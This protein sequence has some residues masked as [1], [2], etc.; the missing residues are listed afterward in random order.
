MKKNVKFIGSTLLVCIVMV[1]CESNELDQVSEF[2]ELKKANLGMIKSYD[3]AM[4][5]KWNEA[6]SLA[7]DNK[8]PSPAESRVYA[9]VT[10]AV[11]DA[12]NNVVPI[13]ETYAMDNSW[14]NGKEVSKKTIYSVADPAVA[15][16]AHDVLV[17]LFPAWKVQA[18][19]LLTS[20]LMEIEDS[21]LK[22]TGIQIGKDAAVAILAKRQYDVLPKFE[23]YPQGT[24]PGEYKSTMP[25]KFP[26]FPVWPVNAVYGPFWGETEPFGILSGDQF[27]P[28]PPYEINT[29]EY[30]AD[31]NEVKIMGSNTSSVRTQEQ[32]DMCV[33]LT[34][35]M[36]SMMNRV[37]R[38]M[39]VQE[40]LDGWETAR[41]FALTHITVA[42]ALICAFDA[43][44]YYKFWRPVTAIQEGDIDGNDDTAGDAIWSP[45]QSARATPAI[46]SYPSG[47]AVAGSGGAEVFK[48]FFRK[49]DK[50]FTVGS[51]SLPNTERSYASF[52]QFGTEMGESRIYGGHNF[53]NDYV[54][55]EEMGKKIAKFVY[56]NN[57]KEL[58][59]SQLKK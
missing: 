14:N 29:T 12:L 30:T 9:M 38:T 17:V 40:D 51:Y 21:E 39:A 36:P 3:N 41:L 4:V 53:R 43:N 11:H 55:G 16:A 6:L 20:S 18:D 57:L 42:D 52:S 49:D 33:F 44:Y 15:Q 47:Y 50:S 27:R 1:A 32:A 31:Y 48:M 7:V 23:S 56:E 37:A 5:L 10:L 25:F 34:D 46:P 13:Y 19:D 35:N 22:A 8:I 54:A 26:N 58:K 28:E 24:L 59:V 2:G 45:L